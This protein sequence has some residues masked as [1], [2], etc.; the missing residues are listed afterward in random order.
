[1]SKELSLCGTAGMTSAGARRPFFVVVP[2][3]EREPSEKRPF[4][5][6]AEATRRMNRVAFAPSALGDSG[7]GREDGA[8]TGG[9]NDSWD[10]FAVCGTRG[11]PVERDLSAL[12]VPRN[13]PSSSPSFMV[14]MPSPGCCEKY[15][16]VLGVRRDEFLDGRPLL[17]SVES[18]EL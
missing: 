9:M 13:F 7:P 18:D 6:G 11:L 15:E 4:A 1:V 5:L 14:S 12:I 10:A 2:W 8:E 16:G 3:A 17:E